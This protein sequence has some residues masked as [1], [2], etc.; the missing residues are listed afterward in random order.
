M[1]YREPDPVRIAE[2]EAADNEIDAYARGL[3]AERRF[4]R[5]RI[6]IVILGGVLAFLAAAFVY[7]RAAASKRPHAACHRVM[8][9]TSG[10]D[11]QLERHDRIECTPPEAS[12]N[13]YDA[14]P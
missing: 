3:A 12:P 1:S 10:V 6:A 9:L 4:D 8:V 13:A 14:L 2:L 7:V 11:G 5:L